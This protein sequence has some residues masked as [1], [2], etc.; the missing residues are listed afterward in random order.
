MDGKTK[1]RI[2]IR[3]I[4]KTPIDLMQAAASSS[5]AEPQVALLCEA[6]ATYHPQY[7]GA[8]GR[9]T[10][11]LTT[12][13]RYCFKD[14][15]EILDY[16]KKV[17]PSHDITNIVEASHYVKV[18]NWC[19]LGSS[20]AAKCKVTRWVKPFRC[21]AA[22]ERARTE[23]RTRSSDKRNSVPNGANPH[24]TRRVRTPPVQAKLKGSPYGPR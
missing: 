14:K 21:L 2:L 7:M 10:P 8:G 3:T 6:G 4:K 24:G 20:S 17:Y 22:R 13:P 9:W 1:L 12:K 18:S 19:K 23:K 16:C 15:M 11:D 5:G